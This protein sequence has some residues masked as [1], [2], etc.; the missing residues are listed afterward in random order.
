MKKKL[1]CALLAAGVFGSASVNAATTITGAEV[2]TIAGE[3]VN[4]LS[5]HSIPELTASD[6]TM[7]QSMYQSVVSTS[8]SQMT[9]YT[10]VVNSSLQSSS[11]CSGMGTYPNFN[12]NLMTSCMMDVSRAMIQAGYTS[13]AASMTGAI[14]IVKA[15]GI[16]FTLPGTNVTIPTGNTGGT[17]PS[18]TIA[19]TVTET[20][21]TAVTPQ[22]QRA[23]S[24]QQAAVISN[25]LSN[26]F[27]GRAPTA[28]RAPARVSL[29]N[30]KGMAA[31][32]SPAKLNAWVN[33]SDTTIGNSASASMFDGTVTNALGGV[34]YRVNDKFVA[35]VSVGYDRVD[36]DFKFLANSGMLSEGWLVAPYASYQISDIISVD[37]A[38]GYAK[39]D[40]DTRASGATSSQ[41]YDRNFLALNMNANYWMNDWQLTGKA[42]YI[43]AEEKMDTTN[44]M[45]QLR[46]GGQIGYWRE[47]IM[48]Y[49]GIAYVRDLKVSSS[50]PGGIPSAADKDA[51]VGS[52]GVNFFSKGAFSAGIS[53]T[54]EFDRD[55][56]KNYTFMANV[57]YRF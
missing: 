42:N 20:I 34:D 6:V 30:E 57:G 2:Q 11:S 40:V 35:G 5:T 44:K 54:E 7:F 14:G 26:V 8:P 43:F 1:L 47:G 18:T 51:W 48:P 24:V 23:T 50:A 10:N 3:V 21:S 37:G 19:R 45:E 25:V 56:S 46:L 52:V 15:A 36:L 49:A 41:S 12:T 31:G 16:P 32:D 13:E 33:A 4:Y 39:G 9:Q 22:I 53:Y 27:S 38:Y 28:P 55:D 29:G 17:T